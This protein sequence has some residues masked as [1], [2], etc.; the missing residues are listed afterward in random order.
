MLFTI[1]V[2]DATDSAAA[3]A[4]TATTA[5]GVVGM[6]R[7]W[8]GGG[9]GGRGRFVSERPK[10]LALLLLADF[11]RFD[12]ARNLHEGGRRQGI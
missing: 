12:D 9:G 6:W 5:I 2:G 1:P 10:K 3:A 11:E 8:A 7:G 4:V